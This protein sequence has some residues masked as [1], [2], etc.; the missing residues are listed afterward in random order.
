MTEDENY[1][2]D[3]AAEVCMGNQEALDFVSLWY[4]W[5]H[6]LDDLIDTMEDGRPVMDKEQMI[7]GFLTSAFL[8]SCP[9]YR[10]HSDVLISCVITTTNAYADSVA[11]ERSPIEHRRNIGNILRTCGNEMFFLVAALVGGINHMRSVSQKIR[12]TDFLRQKGDEF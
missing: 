12:E 9:F 5:C 3:F 8:Y 4:R 11:W 10:K 6:F 7:Q 1:A 2:H